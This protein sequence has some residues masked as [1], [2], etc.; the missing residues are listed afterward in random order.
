MCNYIVPGAGADVNATNSSK[1]TA[2]HIA[3]KYG[4]ID[5]CEMLL[6]A[7][8]DATI[9]NR[10]GKSAVDVAG[11]I[12]V[13]GILM[14]R[15]GQGLRVDTDSP[16]NYP[17]LPTNVNT[18]SPTQLDANVTSKANKEKTYARSSSMKVIRSNMKVRTSP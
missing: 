2:L 15:Q 16:N 1:N 5:Q 7:G 17:P 3:S 18:I 8:A 14:R 6:K 11:D 10:D 4:H 9:R 12:E 13:R